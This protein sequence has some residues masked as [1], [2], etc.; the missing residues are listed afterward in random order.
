MHLSLR[1]LVIVGGLSLLVQGCGGNLQQQASRTQTQDSQFTALAMEEP[2]QKPTMVQPSMALARLP[3]GAG[4]VQTIR[5]WRY[6]NGVDQQISLD[7]ATPKGLENFLEIAARTAGQRVRPDLAVPMAPPTRASIE[8]E[9]IDRFPSMVM[10]VT[11]RPLSNAYGPIGL[12]IGR[13]EDSLRCIYAWQWISDLRAIRPEQDSIAARLN[14]TTSLD[15]VPASVRVKLCRKYATV[16]Q[17]AGYVTQL[18][19]VTVPTMQR[20]M[21]QRG[22]DPRNPVTLESELPA[23]PVVVAAPAPSVKP[24]APV[25]AAPVVKPTPKAEIKTASKPAPKPVHKTAARSAP[26]VHESNQFEQRQLASRPAQQ[27]FDRP[28][29]PIVSLPIPVPAYAATTNPAPA[30][31]PLAPGDLSG[32]RYLAPVNQIQMRAAPVPGDTPGTVAGTAA[33]SPNGPSAARNGA[34]MGLDPSIPMRA[35]LGP[36]NGTTQTGMRP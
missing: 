32:P 31:A 35:Y 21:A 2:P 13:G 6:A 9:L 8:S 27:A 36:R 19:I 14:L 20:L 10:Q 15:G 3:L 4:Q 23:A 11:E 33:P 16:D 25:M 1:S 12:A 26:K 28:A 7:G 29:A 34:L 18:N 24:A 22:I 30:A 17:L 5:E